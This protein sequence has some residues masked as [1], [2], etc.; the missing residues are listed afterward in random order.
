VATRCR[1]RGSRGILGDVLK[2]DGR[3]ARNIDFEIANFQV[4]KKTH[5]K[6]SILR[7]QSVK[8]GGVSHEM[9]V[10]LRPRVS[11]R[12]SGFLWLRRLYR[13]SCKT[14]P[15]PRF[16]SRLSCRFAWQAWRFVTLQ[17]V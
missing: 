14:S 13:G 6:T 11:S 15:F 5:R 4:P 7:L 10:F 3:F 16:P 2:I 17:P 8:I 1:F 9:L 12:V